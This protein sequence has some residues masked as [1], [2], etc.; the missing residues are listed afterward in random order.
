M[1]SDGTIRQL[2]KKGKIRLSSPQ[3]PM[4][5]IQFQ[6][7]S[8]DLRLGHRFIRRA[9]VGDTAFAEKWGGRVTL[10]P[11]ACMIAST[12]EKLTLPDNVIAIVDGKSTWGRKFLV[13]HSTAGYID[14]KFS[15][16][17]TLEMSNI[18]EQDIVVHPGDRI[19]QLRFFWLDAPAVRP[20]GHP[21]LKSHYQGQTGPTLPHM[22]A[23][24]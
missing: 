16:E 24:Q 5:D 10:T 12:V 18:G 8:I 21:E 23:L 1:L 19:C 17:I 14:P 13:V 20:Y 4:E 2:I 3:Y 11:G 6:S 15:G 7:A 9:R 22:E